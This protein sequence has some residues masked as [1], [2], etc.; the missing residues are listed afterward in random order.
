MV[1][2]QRKYA[3]STGRVK[4][5]VAKKRMKRAVPRLA[6]LGPAFARW[7]AALANK[8][9][10]RPIYGVGRRPRRLALAAAAGYGSARR[11]L[12]PLRRP[13]RRSA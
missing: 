2:R 3:F 6:A 10:R 12:N 11:L 7:R 1:Q 13:R 4:T 5:W 8:R 9:A